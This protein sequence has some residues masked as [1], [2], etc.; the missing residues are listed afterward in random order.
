MHVTIS[1]YGVKLV[2]PQ[3]LKSLTDSQWRTQQA[4]I[5][6][7]GSM[8][9]CAPK[10]LSACLPQIVPKLS[11]SFSNTHPK[12]REAGSRALNDICKVIR[13]PEISALGP[14]LK[15]ALSDPA[16]KTRKAL[17]EKMAKQLQMQQS[18]MKK[19]I[20]QASLRL[21]NAQKHPLSGFPCVKGR[22]ATALLLGQRGSG[23]TCWVNNDGALWSVWFAGARGARKEVPGR[24]RAVVA[25]SGGA[26]RGGGK[27]GDSVC[28]QL[29]C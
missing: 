23:G 3:V 1:P 15:A 26:I 24:F 14:V 5:Q 7:L 10:Q 27:R 13:N 28:A 17:E 25:G 29:A 2:L 16:N 19:K 8:A 21:L 20:A 9:F 22:P 6:L 4:A 18:Q 12:V 11:E